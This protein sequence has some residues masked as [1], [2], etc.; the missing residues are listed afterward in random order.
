LN[1]TVQFLGPIGY[2]VAIGEFFGAI[3]LLA[4]V[5]SRFSAAAI[6][7]MIGAVRDSNITC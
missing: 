7:I 5:L 3:A 6:I 4:G 1:G 2:L